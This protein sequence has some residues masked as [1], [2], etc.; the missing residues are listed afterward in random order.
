[1]A[2]AVLLASCWS[3]TDARGGPSYL[4][5]HQILLRLHWSVEEQQGLPPAQLVPVA[6][7]GVQA[8]LKQTSVEGLQQSEVA[9]QPV[10]PL[11]TQPEPLLHHRGHWLRGFH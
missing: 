2:G 3:H 10:A 6:A 5:S 4:A 7:H 9:W 1:M 8:L 11:T